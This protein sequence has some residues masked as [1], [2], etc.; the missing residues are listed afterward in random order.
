M[1]A[2][3]FDLACPRCGGALESRGEHA[4]YCLFDELA[5]IQEHGVWRFLLPERHAHYEQFIRE[6]ETV[7]KAEGRAS[8]DAAFYRALPYEDLTGRHSPAW[9][10]RARSF[11]TFVAKVLAPLEQ[12]DAVLKIVDLGAGN[13]WLSH[14]LVERGHQLAAVDL[15][16]NGW[17]GL[18]AHKYYE[19]PF[20][21]LQA[22][23]DRLPLR[24]GQ[25]GLVVFNAS[26]H[27]SE[28]FS[29]T[30]AEAQRML[31]PG[32]GL[33]IIDTPI[34]YDA[35]SGARMVKERQEAF[36]RQFGFPSNALA[37]ENYL[38]YARLRQLGSEFDLRWR[39]LE[40][41]FGLSWKL[42]RLADRLRAH[43]EPAKLP[44]IVGKRHLDS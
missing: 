23:Y 32:G 12:G 29:A 9:R 19:T 36:T 37:S 5:F 44:V 13:G 38:T 35:T 17:D 20:L 1:N 2:G 18:G 41:A 8:R 7:R 4:A 31:M 25:Y 30:L 22:E 10:V 15:L 14:R 6:Y 24:P 21:C 33:V 40:P 3:G 16:T 26:F 11:D 39:L 28:S 42:G 34:Y 27:Y 43:R